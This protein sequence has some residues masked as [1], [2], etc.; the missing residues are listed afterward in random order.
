M[1]WF[2][3]VI[4]AFVL[5]FAIKGIMN[6]MILGLFRLAGMV[7]GTIFSARYGGGLGTW[8]ANQFDA[9]AQVGQFV[10]YALVFIVVVLLAQVLAGVVRSLLDMVLLG[11]LDKAGGVLFGAMKAMIVVFIVFFAMSFLPDNPLCDTIYR[12][13][14]FYAFYEQTAPGLYSRFIQP[15]LKQ[16]NPIQQIKSATAAATG[17]PAELI[18]SDLF[19]QLLKGSGKFSDKEIELF[20]DKFNTLDMDV[21]KQIID[22][23]KAGKV[24]D[25]FEMLT[26]SR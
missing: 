9:P 26:R 18:G 6:G 12:E 4:L 14:G 5:W 11:W 10:G 8:F 7:L 21:Q 16:H 13:S 25:V 2:D 17:N 23:L 15:V 20:L 3:V 19:R 1:H 22:E 24:D